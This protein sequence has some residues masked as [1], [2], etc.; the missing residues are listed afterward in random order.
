MPYD[1]LALTYFY[2]RQYKKVKPGNFVNVATDISRS[3]QGE[4]VMC[5]HCQRPEII[6]HTTL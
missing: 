3:F 6:L 4:F 1:T 5:Y 2:R